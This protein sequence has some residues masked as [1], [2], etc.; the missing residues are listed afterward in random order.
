LVPVSLIVAY[1]SC[2]ARSVGNTARGHCHGGHG[3]DIG[4]AASLGC[5][6]RYALLTCVSLLAADHMRNSAGKIE[7]TFLPLHVGVTFA[8]APAFSL[9]AR[10]RPAARLERSSQR[11]RS[12]RIG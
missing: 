12:R 1:G 9:G 5:N 4:D 11:D 2:F 7:P 6:V 3:A 10:V 8:L